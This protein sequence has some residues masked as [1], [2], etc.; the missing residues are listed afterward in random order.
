VNNSGSP[1]LVPIES[2]KW[3]AA[4][5][6]YLPFRDHPL[7]FRTFADLSPDPDSILDFVSKFGTLLGLHR[8]PELEDRYESLGLWEL[9]IG[10]VKY[11][12]MC[13]GAFKTHELT[14]I[15]GLRDAL[16]SS[17]VLRNNAPMLPP[18]GYVPQ[19][20]AIISFAKVFFFHVVNR[21][22][23]S[24]VRVTLVHEDGPRI[25]LST[26]PK[27]LIGVIWLQVANSI[28]RDVWH[29]QCAGCGEWFEVSREPT[30]ATRAKRFCSSRCRLRAH[31]AR[32]G[33]ARA[34]KE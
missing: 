29:R 21:R 3:L 23:E 13:I 6:C 2:H 17:E 9:E 33:S 4:G 34:T 27:A 5:R 16:A 30:G 20:E 14:A 10:L 32:K 19:D 7:L 28:T 31:R 25:R 11:A 26:M 15:Q 12:L 1:A 22:L 8:Q 18:S 24:W